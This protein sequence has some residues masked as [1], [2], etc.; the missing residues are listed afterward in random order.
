MVNRACSTFR[1]I[2]YFWSHDN[3]IILILSTTIFNYQVEQEQKISKARK[4]FN[5]FKSLARI[6]KLTTNN[7]DINLCF[8]SFYTVYMLKLSKKILGLLIY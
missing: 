5:Q 3:R 7:F 6:N 2:L 8:I 4:A 1:I